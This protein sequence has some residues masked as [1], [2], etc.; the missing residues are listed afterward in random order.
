MEKRD[1]INFIIDL[2]FVLVMIWARDGITKNESAAAILN[3]IFNN[4]KEIDEERFYE[5]FQK[6]LK[7]A[8]NRKA[9]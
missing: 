6:G 1:K 2:L 3:G 8:E 7:Y 4:L 9:R 5:S